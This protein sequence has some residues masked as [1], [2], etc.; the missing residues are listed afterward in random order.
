MSTL[1]SKFKWLL[2][3]ILSLFLFG[4]TSFA[5]EDN[6]PGNKY[7]L[8]I[9]YLEEKGIIQ[10]Y[11][12]GTFKAHKSINRAEALK[13]LLLASG[14]FSQEEIEGIELTESPF[15]DA[16][17][18]EW[19]TT[20]LAFAKEEGIINGHEDGNYYPWNKIN[21]A[22]SLKIILEAQTNII[23][24][25]VSTPISL[26]E[27]FNWNTQLFRPTEAN[28]LFNDLPTNQWHSKYFAFAASRDMVNIYA[29]NTVNPTQDMS[30]GY[31]SLILYR[32]LT[33]GEGYR[34]GKATFYGAAVQGNGTASG[35]RFDMYKHTAA[36]RTL[37]FGSI[38]EVTNLANGES[39]NVKINDRGP[40]GPG[41]VID[42]SSSAF[43]EIASLGTGVINVQYK[44]ISTPEE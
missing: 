40:Y 38:V 24:P 13:M 8:P 33:Y 32:M 16:P 1:N 18:D 26:D 10:G 30:R 15:A 41:R 9:K 21:L 14:R 12:D 31:L 23:Y 28:H 35:E 2:I 44:V 43:S 5:F 19:Y 20:Y 34:F 29:A 3:P 25:D 22:E 6:N 42:L 4:Q 17:I 11:E 39:V 36:H 7:Y 27:Y 37:P